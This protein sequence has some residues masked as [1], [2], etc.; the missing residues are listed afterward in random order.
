MDASCCFAAYELVQVDTG[1]ILY[2]TYATFLEIKTANENL[3]TKSLTSRFFPAGTF[4]APS[5]HFAV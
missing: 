1:V 3:R 4:S 2:Q 5:I